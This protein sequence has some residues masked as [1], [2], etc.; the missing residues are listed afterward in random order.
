MGLHAGPAQARAVETNCDDAPPAPPKVPVPRG[1][2]PQR[3][4]HAVPVQRP[5]HHHPPLQRRRRAGSALGAPLHA[6]T[7]RAAW[8]A[9]G[10]G[11]PGRFRQNPFA[12]QKGPSHPA[13]PSPPPHSTPPHPTPP[14]PILDPTPPTPTPPPPHPTPQGSILLYLIMYVILMSFGAGTAIPGGLFVPSI[15]VRRAPGPCSTPAGALRTMHRMRPPAACQLL[16]S[17]RARPAANLS[18]P[19]AR[20]PPPC[21]GRRRVGRA[22]GRMAAHVA[23]PLEHPAGAVLP[24]GRDRH[25]RRRVPVRAARGAVT[26]QHARSSPDNR[27]E[28]ATATPER[29]SPCC[30]PPPPEGTPYPWWCS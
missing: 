2:H 17:P 15:L 23:A 5:R 27:N 16:G 29:I 8:R 9:L 26:G 28:A 10:Q 21:P 22:P 30:P 6:G 13:A 24:H 1:G 12:P 20:A 14:H 19:N 18:R 3:P 7:R 25:A 11:G 4:R